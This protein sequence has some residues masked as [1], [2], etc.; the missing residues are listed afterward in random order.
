MQAYILSLHTPSMRGSDQKVKTL[1]FL[2][3]LVYFVGYEMKVTIAEVSTTAY[4]GLLWS[5]MG[6]PKDDDETICRMVKS[7]ILVSTCIP[8]NSSSRPID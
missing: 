5:V 4:T 2:N 7:P 8:L 1:F 6:F 3:S